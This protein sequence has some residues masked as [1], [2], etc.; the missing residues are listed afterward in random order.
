MGHSWRI[1]KPFVRGKE[2]EESFISFSQ[3]EKMVNDDNELTWDE[4]TQLGKDAIELLGE[5]EYRRRMHHIAAFF[6]KNEKPVKGN[7]HFT[8]LKG[9][10]FVKCSS[11]RISAIQIKKMYQVAGSLN[12]KLLDGE[13]I[14]NE[15]RLERLIERYTP[16]RKKI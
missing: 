1:Q 9:H 6:Y 12:G 13:R 4:D 16:K 8:F 10:G 5:V 14:I 3:W 2:I 7:L 11:D 15:E